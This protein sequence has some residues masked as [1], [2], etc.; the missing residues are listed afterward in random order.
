MDARDLVA[1]HCTCG[2]NSNP[3][4]EAE[5]HKRAR[6]HLTAVDPAP[7]DEL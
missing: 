6:R 3:T 5:A 7:E 4:T 1:A 2:Y